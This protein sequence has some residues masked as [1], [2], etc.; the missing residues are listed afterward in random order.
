M[1]DSSNC[2]DFGIYFHWPFCTSLCPYCDFNSHVARSVD[3][4]LWRRAFESELERC[5]SETGDKPVRSIFFGGGT[6]ST[7]P[8]D[9]A[10]AIIEKCLNLWNP[11]DEVEITLEANPGTSDVEKFRSFRDAGVNRLSVG[12]QSLRDE[13]L[14]RLGRMHS[15]AEARLAFDAARSVFD[16]AS[17]DLIYARQFQ[18]L[19]DWRAELAEALE[20]R[21]THLSLYQL[22]IEPGTVFGKLFRAGRLASL[23]SEA[24]EA[25]LFSATQEMCECEGLHAYEVSNHAAKGFECVHNLLYWRSCDYAGIGPGAHGRLTLNGHR[26]STD[27]V[28]SPGD[29][30]ATVM[31]D[32]SGEI[33]RTA[34]GARDEA[35]EYLMMSLRLSE[36][37]DLVRL[38]SLCPELIDNSRIE[39]LE[40]DGLIESDGV[41]L[42]TTLR[43]KLLLNSVLANLIE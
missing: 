5:A 29:W 22:S 15:A 32:G 14:S 38:N 18:S 35:I 23:P 41:S 34:I 40:N 2:S 36:G 37:A 28:K 9:L 6:P 26:F 25:D 4:G 33:S 31:R 8:P 3:Y 27:T 1:A 12:V 24:L 17:M 16:R 19:E 7:M 42:T 21:P 10:A 13:D 20:M 43:G 11:I 39:D 30:I